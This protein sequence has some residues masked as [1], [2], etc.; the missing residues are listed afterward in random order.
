M[1][2]PSHWQSLVLCHWRPMPGS[3]APWHTLSELGPESTL[4]VGGDSGPGSDLSV[5]AGY[6]SMGRPRAFPSS[7]SPVALNLS[8]RMVEARCT[9]V[10]SGGRLGA[11][12]LVNGARPSDREPTGDSS[13]K[14]VG[15]TLI[16]GGTPAIYASTRRRKPETPKRPILHRA[17]FWRDRGAA[18]AEVGRRGL[19]GPVERI[20]GCGGAGFHGRIPR[21]RRAAAVGMSR[22]SLDFA[23]LG[24]RV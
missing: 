6:F 20:G 18:T 5:A 24:F 7:G 10:H 16:H 17:E 8:S 14:Y 23:G 15:H 1:G 2:K 12:G 9:Y 19:G 11:W 13:A 4:A 21:R 22:I 3:L